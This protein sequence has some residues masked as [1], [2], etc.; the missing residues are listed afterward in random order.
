MKTF[1]KIAAL[2]GACALQAFLATAANANTIVSASVG[3]AAVGSVRDNLDSLVLGNSTQLS[4]TGILVSFTPDGGVV[5]GN[6]SGIYAAPFLS[7]MNGNGFGSPSQANGADLTN[8]LTAGGTSTSSA[9]LTFSQN[10]KAVGLLWGSI[11][12]YNTLLLEENGVV[13][14]TITGSQAAAAASTLPTG[15]Q[16]TDDRLREH[17]VGHRLQPDR[18]PQHSARV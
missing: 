2:A 11:D 8:Y 15:D 4:A 1:T 13:V 12:T 3:G 5:S 17:L 14:G 7:G 9:T 18:R 16:S 10:L 6:S